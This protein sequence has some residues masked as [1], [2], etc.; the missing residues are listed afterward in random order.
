MKHVPSWMPGAGFKTWAAN[1]RRKLNEMTRAPL[2]IVKEQM[3]SGT[4]VPSYT[5]RNLANTPTDPGAAHKHEDAVVWTAAAMYVGTADTSVAALSTFAL[6]MV[7]NPDVQRK[8][9][10]EIDSLLGGARLPCTDDKPHLPY[11][12][13]LMKE[14]MS[15]CYMSHHCCGRD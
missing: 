5:S 3:A 1:S 13:A 12:E 8:A 10:A 7:R 4:A 11:V 2:Q 15:T 14:C 9:Q 6:L